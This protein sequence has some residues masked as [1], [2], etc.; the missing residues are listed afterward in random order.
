MLSIRTGNPIEEHFDATGHRIRML[1]EPVSNNRYAPD[2][3]AEDEVT[4]PKYSVQRSRALID[5]SGKL[6]DRP[7]VFLEVSVKK[8]IFSDHPK[9][10]HEDHLNAIL[11]ANYSDY[12]RHL[13]GGYDIHSLTRL[14]AGY[15][16]LQTLFKEVKDNNLGN[17][18]Y[19]KN[20]IDTT[21]ETI[22]V[23]SNA[24]AFKRAGEEFKYKVYTAWQALKNERKRKFSSG[25]GSSS[26][27][28]GSTS[29]RLEL[30][31]TESI[32]RLFGQ[33]LKMTKLI[34]NILESLED[35]FEE[36]MYN[37]DLLMSNIKRLRSE[38]KQEI[39]LGESQK[40]KLLQCNILCLSEQ[41]VDSNEALELVSR[42]NKKLSRVVK[43]E[44]ERRKAVKMET[45]KA[46]L[47]VNGHDVGCTKPRQL[48]FPQFALKFEHSFHVE[49]TSRPKSIE[50]ELLK[51]GQ[52]PY[53][54][55]SIATIPVQFLGILTMMLAQL[56]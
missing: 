47:K 24:I 8:L 39:E 51:Q 36:N 18:A 30:K 45:Y 4:D 32:A 37:I 6:R 40:S 21:V 14:N 26:Q 9:F 31:P 2:L 5:S 52:F 48:M 44:I 15:N 28:N 54:Y 16:T 53:E 35:V 12:Y 29:S 22:D 34:Q 41:I 20:L 56:P 7:P 25:R 11:L 10:S 27:L 46:R 17:H 50:I 55:S 19:G 49:V 1:P 43:A 42:G 38:I 33:V 3:P 23:L 13:K